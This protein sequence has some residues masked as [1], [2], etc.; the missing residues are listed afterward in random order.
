[1]NTNSN[2]LIDVTGL[3]FGYRSRTILEDVDMHVRR[4]QVVSIM[5]PSG[6]GKTTLMRLITGQVR[7]QAGKVIVDGDSV[8]DLSHRRLL[9]LR[10]KMGV[11]LQ[12]GALLTDLNVY[13]NV[14]YPL[15]EHTK[16]PENLI[17]IVVMLKLEAV[18]L[19]GARDLMPSDL[20]GG[21]ARRVALAR[22]IVLDPVLVLYD[23]PFTGLDPISKGIAAK[24]VRE[25]NDSLGLTSILISH[26]VAETCAISDYVYLLG[27]GRVL[28]HGT[29]DEMLKSEQPLVKQFM[30]ASPEG[31]VP[32][33]Y[34]AKNYLQDLMQ[35][36][37]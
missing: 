23:E 1:M 31:P 33:H 26:D 30:N 8:P 21:M 12:S 36:S 32:F 11:M 29:P 10:K 7:P 35:E 24:L 28:G 17:R 14:A 16:L 3:R 15:R 19:R 27:D 20:S 34:P 37:A 2:N 13:E 25:V 5:G 18:G 6:C 22:A 4:G 9:E